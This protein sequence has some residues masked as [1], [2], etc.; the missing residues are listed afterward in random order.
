MQHNQNINLT[1]PPFHPPSLPQ[2][3]DKLDEGA[4]PAHV[5]PRSYCELYK[6][7][8]GALFRAHVEGRL[9]AEIMRAPA[10]FVEPDPDLAQALL[11]Q[12]AAGKAL[13]LITNS[14]AAY[15]E[16]AAAAASLWSLALD[17]VAHSCSSAVTADI[18]PNC[19]P[20]AV[21]PPAPI[22]SAAA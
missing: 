17:C 2:M 11:D 1:F 22:C 12:R 3:T 9:K 18:T 19:P 10:A 8:A 14:D 7:V 4:I 21:H 16:C 20:T 15:T 13:A 5:C 6:L